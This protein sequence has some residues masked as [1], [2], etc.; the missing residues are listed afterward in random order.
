MVSW[1]LEMSMSFRR[2]ESYNCYNESFKM[3]M[4]NV[5]IDISYFLEGD[6]L[7]FMNI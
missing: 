1:S 3:I 5:N 7:R 4:S 6:A 2:N